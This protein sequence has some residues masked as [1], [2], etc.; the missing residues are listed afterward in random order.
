MLGGRFIVVLVP[1]MV[2]LVGSGTRCDVG[3][4]AGWCW[5]LDV[6]FS[7]LNV[8][9]WRCARVPTLCFLLSRSSSSATMKASARTI[10]GVISNRGSSLSE[11]AMRECVGRGA[12]GS[13]VCYM[14]ASVYLVVA[15]WEDTHGALWLSCIEWGGMKDESPRCCWRL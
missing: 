15:S 12:S 2:T 6:A 7:T 5:G 8:F 13:G 10:S 14:G 3:G 11:D 1:R 4:G 9:T